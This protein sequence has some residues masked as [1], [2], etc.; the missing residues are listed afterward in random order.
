MFEELLCS[1]DSGMIYVLGKDEKKGSSNIASRICDPYMKKETLKTRLHFLSRRGFSPVTGMYS[2]F[3]VSLPHIDAIYFN[4]H[5]SKCVVKVYFDL[6]GFS[7]AME[8]RKS[9]WEIVLTAEHWVE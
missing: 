6:S 8:R 4:P 2:V 3:G 9:R 5:L 1:L 7:I